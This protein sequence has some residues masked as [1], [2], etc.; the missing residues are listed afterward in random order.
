[1]RQ[2]IIISGFGGQG[3]MLAGMM[4]CSAAVRENKNTTFF[5]SYGAEMRGGTANCQV[6]I[7]DEQIGSPIVY[8]PDVLI[9]LNDHAFDRFATKVKKDGMVL[10]NISLFNPRD[11][12]G[13]NIVKVN[14]NELAEECGSAV[15]L[16]MIML[17]VVTRITSLVDIKS[18]EDS[19]PELLTEKKKNFWPMNIK[20]L[21]KGFSS[22]LDI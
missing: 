9:A 17:G 1:M 2:E 10:A 14:G 8:D 19:I 15:L 18:L 16:N 12:D 4:L 7:S 13:V 5:P 6:I 22:S 11:I 3:V 20:A 21:D